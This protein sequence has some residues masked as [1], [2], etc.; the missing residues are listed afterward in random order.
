MPGFWDYICC[1]CSTSTEDQEVIQAST[2]RLRLQVETLERENL[3][4]KEELGDLRQQ[5]LSTRNKHYGALSSSPREERSAEIAQVMFA[6]FINDITIVQSGSDTVTRDELR[7]FA[8][9]L[10]KELDSFAHGLRQELRYELR[11]K[12]E[13]TVELNQK[14]KIAIFE[15]LFGYT[16]ETNF[17]QCHD[18][19][20]FVAYKD[21]LASPERKEIEHNLKQQ[22]LKDAAKRLELANPFLEPTES[23]MLGSSSYGELRD[24]T[25]DA[26]TAL[27]GRTDIIAE[28]MD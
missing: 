21:A 15:T 6:Q 4:F 20:A 2:E 3:K 22:A 12:L 11:A 1:C 5:L 16:L 27:V 13:K 19:A 23:T 17:Q 28:S 26:S 10:T 14:Q 7:R 18:S 25:D 9:K 24:V 8:Q